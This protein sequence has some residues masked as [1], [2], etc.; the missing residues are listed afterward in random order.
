[1][2]VRESDPHLTAAELAAW[3]GMLRVHSAL[4]HQLDQELEVEHRLSLRAYEVLVVLESAPDR[5]LR[6]SDLSR[7]VLLSP[8]GVSR[9]VDRLEADGLVHRQRCSDDGRGFFAM[10]TDEGRRRLSEARATHLAG[11][12]R[13]FLEHFETAELDELAGFW[14]RVDPGAVMP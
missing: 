11:V 3:R 7:S 14:Q 12:R 4:F 9:L 8:S 1:M 10:L 13:L 2:T 6:M 5:R